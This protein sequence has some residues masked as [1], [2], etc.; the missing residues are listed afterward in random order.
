MSTLLSGTISK[1][2]SSLSLE[3]FG[4][5]CQPFRLGT[6]EKWDGTWP[7]PQKRKKYILTF[8]SRRIGRSDLTTSRIL[9]SLFAK[10][11]WYKD[12]LPILCF[13]DISCSILSFSNFHFLDFWNLFTFNL[14]TNK[15]TIFVRYRYTN[16][17]KKF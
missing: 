12:I 8:I 7:Y 4:L 13:Y 15:S 14:F 3:T 5:G 11:K 9:T 10:Q 1:W 6:L 16:I 2:R 17:A